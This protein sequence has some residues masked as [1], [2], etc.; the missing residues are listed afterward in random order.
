MER[1]KINKN[2]RSISIAKPQPSVSV[3][4]SVLTNK[5]PQDTIESLLPQLTDEIAKKLND[6]FYTNSN[7]IHISVKEKDGQKQIRLGVKLLTGE[8]NWLPVVKTGRNM[9]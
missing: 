4:V 2:E 5:D 3:T 9:V 7:A 1:K 6:L 8:K